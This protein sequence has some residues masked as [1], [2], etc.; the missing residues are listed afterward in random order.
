MVDSV[1]NYDQSKISQLFRNYMLEENNSDAVLKKINDTFND[2]SEDLIFYENILAANNKLT[3]DILALA[4][5]IKIKSETNNLEL[6]LSKLNLPY[7]GKIIDDSLEITI[8]VIKRQKTG[9]INFSYYEF[10]DQ[11][12]DDQIIPDN[13]KQYLKWI[14]SDIDL[15]YSNVEKAD[16]NDLFNEYLNLS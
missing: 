1:G 11:Y 12:F 16:E 3:L 13:I 5:L 8:S 2:V 7:Y 6:D 10:A 14:K 15:I 4:S 9:K